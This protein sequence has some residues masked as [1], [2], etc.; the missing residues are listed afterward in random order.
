[1]NDTLAGLSIYRPMNRERD[2]REEVLKNIKNGGRGVG[3]GRRGGGGG[4]GSGRKIWKEQRRER[5][6]GGDKKLKA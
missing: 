4:G 6:A 1:M 2:G 3:G 5:R